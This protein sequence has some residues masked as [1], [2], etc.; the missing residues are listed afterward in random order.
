MNYNKDNGKKVNEHK[1]KPKS[2]RKG[3]KFK[4]HQSKVKIFKI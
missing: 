4:R 1:Y 2:K 3:K